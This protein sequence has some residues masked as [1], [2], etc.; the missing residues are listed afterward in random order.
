MTLDIQHDAAL[1]QFFIVVDGHRCVLDYQFASGTMTITHTG[2]PDAVGGRGI[3]AALTQSALEH[4]RASG[5]KVV[6][7]CTY[8]AAYVRRHPE[9]LAL[10]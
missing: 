4:A 9:Y 8:A 1:R 5:W 6:P 7:A 2:V 3:A 10:L